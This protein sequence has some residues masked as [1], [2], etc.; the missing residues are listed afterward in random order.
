MKRSKSPGVVGLES[1]QLGVYGLLPLRMNNG[2]W[3]RPRLCYYTELRNKRFILSHISVIWEMFS[4]RMTSTFSQTQWQWGW[5]GGVNIVADKILELDRQTGLATRA[6]EGNR[7][8]NRGRQMGRW[9]WRGFGWWSKRRRW[10][11]RKFKGKKWPVGWRRGRGRVW[12]FWKRRGRR[13]R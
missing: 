11:R 2:L 13:C 1:L 7:I 6:M 8:R 12:R 9:N 5:L 4:Q 3:I 10:R